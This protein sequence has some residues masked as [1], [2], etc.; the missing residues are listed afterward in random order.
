MVTEVAAVASLLTLGALAAGLTEPATDPATEAL[1]FLAAARRG[2][3][4]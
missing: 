1:F 4:T 3:E 2:R